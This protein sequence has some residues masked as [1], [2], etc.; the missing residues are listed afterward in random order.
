[1]PLLRGFLTLLLFL[2]LGEALR[3][4]FQWPVSGGIIGMLLLSLWAMLSGGVRDDVALASQKL[5]A[6]LI[7]LLMPGVVGVFFLGNRFDGQWPAIAL[8]LVGGTF[9]SVLSTLALLRL[10]LPDSSKARSHD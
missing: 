10:Q 3:L 9:L 8:A 4:L 7:V 5:I 6:I 2:M 1:M